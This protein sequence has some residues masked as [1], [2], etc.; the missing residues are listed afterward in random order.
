M[1]KEKKEKKKDKDKDDKKEEKRGKAN[2]DAWDAAKQVA[3]TLRK[4]RKKEDSN[5]EGSK[6]PWREIR[7]QLRQK[8]NIVDLD[9]VPPHWTSESRQMADMLEILEKAGFKRTGQRYYWE[10]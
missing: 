1:V 8:G 9:A 10:D 5:Y 2:M 7:D 4:E 3:K 6:L